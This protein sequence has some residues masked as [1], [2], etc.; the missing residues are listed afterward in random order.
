[1]AQDI[2]QLSYCEIRENLLL[3]MSWNN[4][5]VLRIGMDIFRV[6]L[7]KVSIVTPSYQ[8]IDYIEQTILSVIKQDYPALE[9]IVVD[10]ASTDGTLDI[11]RRYETRLHWISEPDR[12]QAEAIN[13]GFALASGDIFGWL[14]SD[15]YHAPGV[16]H[17][18]AEFFSTH[19]EAMFVY[20][21]VVGVD[22]KG[23]EFGVRMHVRQRQQLQM[24]DFDVLVQRYDFL[25]Q[26]GCFWRASIWREIGQLD[27]TRRYVLDYE[28]WM[29]VAQRYPMHYLPV[30]L[31]YERLYRQ[32]K[33]GSGDVER[34][35]EIEQ[36]ALQYGG[37]GLPNNYRAEAAA[38][39]TMRGLK[40]AV[41]G[42]CRKA[43][44]D[45]TDAISQ[46][47]PVWKYLRYLMVILLFG[48]HAIPTAWLWL[49]RLRSYHLPPSELPDATSGA[50]APR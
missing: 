12:G 14:N 16:L 10:G 47:T 11:L 41:R 29:R 35:Q 4:S 5:N 9:Y 18:V 45:F 3:Y 22:R 48:Q 49:N 34:I 20:G 43:H 28:Y 38:H 39:F 17:R 36:I 24:S 46:Q 6:A 33:T 15:D 30:V 8:H 42:Q 19:P 2:L 25:V 27:V 32:A 1:L 31:A 26:P 40:K 44:E 23:R 13:K 21:D 50:S 7:P 37:K